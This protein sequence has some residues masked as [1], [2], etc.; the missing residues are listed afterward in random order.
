MKKKRIEMTQETKEKMRASHT[1]LHHSAETKQRISEGLKRAHNKPGARERLSKVA[2]LRCAKMT[3]EQKVERYNYSIEWRERESKRNSGPNGANWRGGKTSLEDRVRRNF[4]S[5]IWKK[6]IL[7]RDNNQCQ[8]CGSFDKLHVHHITPVNGL[9]EKHKTQLL[10]GDYDIPELWN[11]DNGIVYC[12]TC[13]LAIH[14]KQKMS[15]KKRMLLFLKKLRFLGI[16]LPDEMNTEL[17]ELLQ[18]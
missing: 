7:L 13:H 5:R 3:E 10:S 18:T 6:A 17:N 9:I 12:K 14:G 16:T 4:R 2:K 11:P 8:L 1:G 15:Q